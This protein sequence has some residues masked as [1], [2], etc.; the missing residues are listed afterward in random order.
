MCPFAA[1][2]DKVLYLVFT[3]LLQKYEFKAPDDAPMPS[4]ESVPGT[5]RFPRKFYVCP[6][7]TDS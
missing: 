1:I 3:N 5:V 6:Y 2:S 4:T 7:P